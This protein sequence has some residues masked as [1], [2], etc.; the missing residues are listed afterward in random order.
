MAFSVAVG[1]CNEDSNYQSSEIKK[2]S[3][4]LPSTV[5][6][7]VKYKSIKSSIYYNVPKI[8]GILREHMPRWETLRKRK[9]WKTFN[10]IIFPAIITNFS[11]MYVCKTTTG[12][13]FLSSS[14]KVC[15]WNANA[16]FGRIL[17][18]SWLFQRNKLDKFQIG[19]THNNKCVPFYPQMK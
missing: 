1:A 11:F 10:H 12:F 9:N 16:Y 3:L 8:W 18:A 15:V 17:T 19:K 2:N 14:I 4:S 6:S 13:L 7:T 5:T